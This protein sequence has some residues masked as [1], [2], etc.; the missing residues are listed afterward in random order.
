MSKSSGGSEAEAAVG[1]GGAGQ[2]DTEGGPVGW[3]R[4]HGGHRPPTAPP[5]ADLPGDSAAS[6][7]WAPV[8]VVAD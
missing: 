5:G 4:A 7:Q 6:F 3:P 1:A 2:G 8:T